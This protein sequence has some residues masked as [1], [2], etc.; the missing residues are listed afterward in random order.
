MVS[1]LF[2][3]RKICTDKAIRYVWTPYSKLFLVDVFLKRRKLLQTQLIDKDNLVYTCY[4]C[5]GYFHLT[6]AM[7]SKL[8][9]ESY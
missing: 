9:E 1:R 3:Q 2:V 4:T 8:R 5:D 6:S 7:V